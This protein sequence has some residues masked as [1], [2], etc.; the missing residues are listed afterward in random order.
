MFVPR[1]LRLKGVKETQKHK[2]KKSPDLA[3]ARASSED[4]LVQAMQKTSTNSAV[5]SP[6]PQQEQD[7][8]QI[9]HK[10]S[11]QITAPVP[12]DYLAQLA[13]GVELIFTDYAHQ[14]QNG[15]KWLQERYRTADTGEKC[16]L[17]NLPLYDHH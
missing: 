12:S 14:N 13:A 11:K 4:A 1:A 8:M 2:P 5:T 15:A 16:R 9:V 17:C 3:A 10:G 6:M 7:A